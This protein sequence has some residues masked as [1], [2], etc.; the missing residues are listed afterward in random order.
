M[1]NLIVLAG[2]SN[3]GKSTSLKYLDHSETF[4]VSC[5]NKQLQIPGFRKKYKKVAIEDKKL[6]GN[7]LVS[8]SYEKIHK[9]LDIVNRTRPD[10]KTVVVDDINYC[11]SGEIMDN[12]LV[13]G[14]EKFTMQ[15]KNYYDLITSAGEL[16]DDLTVVFIS[17]IIND[18][19]DIDPQYKM[20]SS[21]KM[22]DKTVNIDGLFSYIIYSERYIDEATGEVGYR[23][24]TRTDGND[25]C[26]SVAG[27][28]SEKYIEPNMQTIIDTINKFEEGEE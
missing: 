13:K 19:T 4:I 24:K 23:F 14:Y 11:L 10:I 9:I 6:V 15:A 12:A 8:N 7:W 27:C 5:T 3:S 18:G 16:R 22:L 17:H 25:T 2:F 1:A 28:F 26:R 21:G 20:Y